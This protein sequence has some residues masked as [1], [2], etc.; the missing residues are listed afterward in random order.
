MNSSI[1][2][3][4]T[5]AIASAG[6]ILLFI[7]GFLISGNQPVQSQQTKQVYKAP[8]NTVAG[9]TTP[10]AVKIDPPVTATK[11][12]PVP[13]KKAAKKITVKAV[14]PAKSPVNITQDEQ[15]PLDEMVVM[16]MAKQGDNKVAVES[17]SIKEAHPK[18]GWSGFDNY[19]KEKAVSPDGRAGTVKLSFTV[20]NDGSYTGFKIRNGLTDVANQKA[21]ELIK[22]GPAWTCNADGSTKETTVNVEF[23]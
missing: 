12:K 16:G 8:V 14:D 10:A 1:F 9:G 13:H 4:K 5:L 3:W 2:P 11:H 7:G 21:I 22:N 20:N 18:N 19:L 15:T 23:H 17:S 6:L